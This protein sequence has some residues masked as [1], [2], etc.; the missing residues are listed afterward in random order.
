MMIKDK[1][2]KKILW[3]LV[4]IVLLSMIAVSTK[5]Q[6]NRTFISVTLDSL[7]QRQDTLWI[8]DDAG[9]V[10]YIRT[11][12]DSLFLGDG[13]GEKAIVNLATGGTP[14]GSTTYSQY[15]DAGS[16]GG[17]ADV[18]HYTDSLVVS[19][20]LKVD[21]I[22]VGGSASVDTIYDV[23]DIIFDTL[24][25]TGGVSIGGI[26]V[27]GD[28]LE[29]NSERIG[30]WSDVG[31][32]TSYEITTI[33][34]SGHTLTL[35]DAGKL[36][37]YTYSSGGMTVTVPTNSSVAFQIGT[38]IRI[39]IASSSGNCVPSSPGVTINYPAGKNAIDDGGTGEFIKIGTDEWMLTGDLI[40]DS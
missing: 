25:V 34:T 27:L 19:K 7:T 22:S 17:D 24:N 21:E 33:A 15:N 3:W 38:R 4:A 40:I 20:L 2:I 13:T 37:V 18:K 8:T 11:R 28:S 1:S 5:A 26:V 31:G 10:S 29:L 39:S 9:S 16:F 14:G 35:A 23:N 12:G 30:Q 36:L 32:G 6:H